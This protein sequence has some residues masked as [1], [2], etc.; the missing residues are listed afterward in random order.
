LS[1]QGLV[2]F[3]SLA[4]TQEGFIGSY[5]ITDGLIPRGAMSD[6]WFLSRIFALSKAW[7][8]FESGPTVIY[9]DRWY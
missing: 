6:S 1:S 3:K 4:K 2:S 8:K 5:S 7:Q 9:Y